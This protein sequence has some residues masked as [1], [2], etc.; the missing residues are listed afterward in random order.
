MR[1][2]PTGYKKKNK[3]QRFPF[4]VYIEGMS[5]PTYASCSDAAI[6]QAAHRYAMAVG[7]ATPLAVWKIKN[8]ELSCEVENE[9]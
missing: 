8:G 1:V 7:M 2:K 4:V 5:F 3:V 9:G 6:S